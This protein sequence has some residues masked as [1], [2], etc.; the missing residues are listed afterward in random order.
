M[1]ASK[2]RRLEGDVKANTA[3]RLK[4]GVCKQVRLGASKEM[5]HLAKILVR[6]RPSPFSPL[7]AAAATLRAKRS[8]PPSLK[9]Q[10]MPQ[11]SLLVWTM[12]EYYEG[13]LCDQSLVG[14]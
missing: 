7:S 2:T 4:G 14:L 10:T 5:Y 11:L 1:K 8:S 9:T 12:C 6:R 13:E 3:R